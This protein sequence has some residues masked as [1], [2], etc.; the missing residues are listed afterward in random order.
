MEIFLRE[1]ELI[2]KKYENL[3]KE[4]QFNVFKILRNKYDEVNL[5]S[6]FI[7]ELLNPKGK[8]DKKNTFLKLFLK[9]LG[10]SRYEENEKIIVEKEKNNIDILIRSNNIVYII[11]NKI[12]ADDQDRQLERYYNSVKNDYKFI[13][14]I[15]LTP[16]GKEPSDYSLGILKKEEF[17]DI[18]ITASYLYNILNWIDESIKESALNPILRETLTQYKNLIK[19]ITGQTM[20]EKSKKEIYDLLSKGDNIYSAQSIASNWNYIKVNVELAFWQELKEEIENEEIYTVLEIQKFNETKIKNQVER[21]RNSNPWYG[22]MFEI[23]SNNEDKFCLLIERGDSDLYF[24]ITVVSDGQRNHEIQDKYSEF[25]KKLVD[26]NS[27]KRGPKWLDIKNLSPEINFE[28][29]SNETTL[30]LIHEDERKK[31]IEENWKEIKKYIE[32]VRDKWNEL[33]ET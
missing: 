32:N 26:N 23:F 5:H 19:E 3:N 13:Y 25:Y 9:E 10:V 15:Y 27:V 16:Y 12:W 21:K 4:N 17:K 2:N 8:H 6:R 7:Y 28:S 33:N 14:L 22:L 11:E 31:Y 30:N 20:N 24:G 1:I 18:V 29:F